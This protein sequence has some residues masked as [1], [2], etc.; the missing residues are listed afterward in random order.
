MIENDLKNSEN[1]LV[2]NGCSVSAG[3]ATIVG[4]LSGV[5]PAHLIDEGE[6]IILAIKPSLWF[7]VFYAARSIGLVVAILLALK[8]F[9]FA[10]L[11]LYQYISQIAAAIIFIQLVMGVLEWISRLYVL[12]DRRVI[13]IKGIFNIDIFEGPLIKIQNTY[14]TF[15][16]HERLVGVGTILIATA[17]TAG[18]DAAWQNIN[19]PLEVHER[20]RIAIREAHR[21]W[22]N[23]GGP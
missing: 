11:W 9:P 13:R 14:L 2:E 19:Q 22:P 17:G 20:I 6:Q 5:V 18:I 15:A 8:Y 1:K 23:G 4:S 7:I 10:P 3:Q 16:L 12:T 21:R